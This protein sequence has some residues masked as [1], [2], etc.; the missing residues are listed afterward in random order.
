MQTKEQIQDSQEAG[1]DLCRWKQSGS[2]EY[3]YGNGSGYAGGEQHQYFLP[4]KT[5]AGHNPRYTSA[6]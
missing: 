3:G 4:L 1:A 2:A 6:G 5:P